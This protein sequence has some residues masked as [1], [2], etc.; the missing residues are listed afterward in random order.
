[1][2]TKNI[3]LFLFSAIGTTF[4]VNGHCQTGTIT[5]YG[6]VNKDACTGVN[7][8][9]LGPNGVVTLPPM[10]GR[11]IWVHGGIPRP[12]VEFTISLSGCSHN[13]GEMARAYFYSNNVDSNGYLTKTSGTGT[14]WGYAILPPNSGSHANRL[15]ITSSPSISHQ[16]TNPGVSPT[17]GTATLSYMVAYAALP[18]GGGHYISPEP[19]TLNAQANY[20]IYFQ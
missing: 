12:F 3:F 17:G 8:N 14:G 7:V 15:M 5:L 1:M 10:V 20:V 19:G 6:T 13:P 4:G 9:G 2:K 18:N 11:S 16:S